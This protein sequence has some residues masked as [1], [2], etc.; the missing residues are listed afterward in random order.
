MII[1]FTLHVEALREADLKMNKTAQGPRVVGWGAS[2]A[3]S[4][5][6]DGAGYHPSKGCK[7]TAFNCFFNLIIMY[8]Y[9]Y[10]CETQ[11]IIVFG[12]FYNLKNFQIPFPMNVSC[13]FHV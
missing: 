13:Q 2:D 12:F 8:I 9:Y 6:R 1:S 11:Q 5:I 7:N 3:A 10:F 4:P